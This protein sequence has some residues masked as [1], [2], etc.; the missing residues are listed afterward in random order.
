MAEALT[1]QHE[2]S[3]IHDQELAYLGA[4][5]IEAQRSSDL[6]AAVQ[7]H[8]EQ[9]G[10]QNP[11]TGPEQ[12]GPGFSLAS[13]EIPMNKESVYR[14][15]HAAAIGDLAVSGVVRNGNT[16]RGEKNRRWGDRVF[17]DSGADGA[18]AMLGGRTVIEANK[19]AARSGWVTAKEVTGVFAKDSDGIVKNLIK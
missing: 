4:L 19:D 7:K 11:N 9:T 16:A 3:R 18:K 1:A 6:S 8:V 2:I 13:G 17:W 5:V 15:V 12:D 14:Q 10:L